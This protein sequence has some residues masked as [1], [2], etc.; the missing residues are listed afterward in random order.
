MLL[1]TR[2]KDWLQYSE[3]LLEIANLLI[4]NKKFSWACF[5]LQQA[6]AAALKSILAKH[7]EMTFGDNLIKLARTIAETET[8]PVDVKSS[9]LKLNDLFTRA[10]DLETKPNGT[11]SNNYT[12]REANDTK[13][14]TLV[15]IRYAHHLNH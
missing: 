11:P 5:T 12:I 2:E 13:N 14:K 6:S 3:E 7:D 4:D 8:I 9:C 1:M 15:I 10:R